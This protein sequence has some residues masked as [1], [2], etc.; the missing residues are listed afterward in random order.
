MIHSAFVLTDHPHSRL[1]AILSVPVPPSAENE[2]A[3]ACA[4]S[5]HRAGVGA[6]VT[7]D[8]DSQAAA[9]ASAQATAPIAAARRAPTV[10]RFSMRLLRHRTT[11]PPRPASAI[12]HD[13]RQPVTPMTRSP[14]RVYKLNAGV[15]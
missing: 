10:I 13:G 1:V 12:S 11:H 14:R 2:A 4:S 5:P 7:L 9:S 6:V 3:D 8:E 15:P